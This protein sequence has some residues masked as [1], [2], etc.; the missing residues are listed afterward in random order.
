MRSILGR[1]LEH[2]RVMAFENGGDPDFWLGSAD[3]MHR[4]LDRR[5]ETLVRVK[6]PAVKDRLAAMLDRLT[7]DDVLRWELDVEG[8]WHRQPA[9]GGVDV[10]GELLRRARE[11]NPVA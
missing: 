8:Q 1:F 9:S 5:I 3:L 7:G 2:S 10:Q 11:L 4:N 6:D